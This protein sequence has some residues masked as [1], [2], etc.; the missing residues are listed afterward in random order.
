M[1]DNRFLEPLHK[2][3]FQIAR[4]SFLESD[5]IFGIYDTKRVSQYDLNADSNTKQIILFLSHKHIWEKDGVCSDYM[6]PCPIKA[7]ETCK[8]ERLHDNEYCLYVKK[9]ITEEEIIE[10]FEE[11]GLEYNKEFEEFMMDD[12]DTDIEIF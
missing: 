3:L 9:Y 1:E 4:E 5:L 10:A 2:T 8:I 12:F 7:F 6:D 11:L